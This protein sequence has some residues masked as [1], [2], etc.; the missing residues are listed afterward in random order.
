M[1]KLINWMWNSVLHV[2][3]VGEHQGLVHPKR[4]TD[5][6]LTPM[7]TESQVKFN[8]PQVISGALQE[9]SAGA[10]KNNNKKYFFHRFFDMI[11]TRF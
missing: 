11:M 3:S 5:Y 9:N 4:K 2:L 10:F 1:I 6:P 8:I 7:Q